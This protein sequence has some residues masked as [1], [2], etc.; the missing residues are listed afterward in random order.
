M[1]VRTNSPVSEPA[2]ESLWG[3]ARQ[4][5]ID[6]VPLATAFSFVLLAE[7]GD[8]TQICAMTLSARSS[9]ISVFAGSMLAFFV[10]DGLSALVGGQLLSFLPYEWI[11]LVSGLVFIIFGGFSLIRRNEK[12]KIEDQKAT[13]LKAFSLVALMELG[14]KTQL[15]SIFLAAEL[16]NPLIVVAGIM[17]AFSVVTAIGVIF[18][19]RILRLLPEKYLKIGA[20]ALFIL[21]GI[22]FILNA[23]TDVPFLA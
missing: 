10:V 17:A 2:S 20:S 15:A 18:G 14:D 9:T 11:C 13:F 19:C 22:V 7:L 5:S 12:P 23:V 8:K 6:I 4:V 3:E 16:R 21:F 1:L